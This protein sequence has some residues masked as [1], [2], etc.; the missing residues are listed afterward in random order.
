[1][2][3]CVR[4]ELISL[5]SILVWVLRVGAWF[6][7]WT[8]ALVSCC[9]LFSILKSLVGVCYTDTLSHVWQ[10]LMA[11]PCVV[12]NLSVCLHTLQSVFISRLEGAIL[13]LNIFLFCCCCCQVAFCHS[14]FSAVY[15]WFFLKWDWIQSLMLM[16]ILLQLNYIGISFE[17]IVLIILW[18]FAQ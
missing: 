12:F 14:D 8:L 4:L 10:W 9:F 6:G 15:I 2:K 17:S 16:A 11:I 3:I 13:S 1:M 18:V 7:V 5:I